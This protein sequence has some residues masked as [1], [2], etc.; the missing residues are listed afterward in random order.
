MTREEIKEKIKYYV[1]AAWDNPNEIDYYL[2]QLP[3]ME[4]HYNDDALYECIGHL[5][6]YTHRR[7]YYD[8]AFNELIDYY[9]INQKDYEFK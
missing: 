1:E 5:K 2:G 8:I 7:D 4:D 6:D 9:Y 3:M